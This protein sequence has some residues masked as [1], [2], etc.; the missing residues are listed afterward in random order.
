MSNLERLLSGL[1]FTHSFDVNGRASIADLLQSSERC[2][3]YVLHCESAEL[4][5]GLSVNVVTRYVQHIKNHK[6]IV[7][8]SFKCVSP[9]KLATEEKLVIW[10]LEKSGV[11]LRNIVHTSTTYAPSIF[12]EI[13]SA[14]E[15]ERWLQDAN[16]TDLTGE[17]LEIPEARRKY[18][19][20]YL[21]FKQLPC[22]DEVIEIAREY[23]RTCIP[24]P[25]RSE[26]YYWSCSCL[27]SNLKMVYVR[28]NVNRQ[29]VFVIQVVD[30]QIICEWQVAKTPLQK[31]Y[32]KWLVYPRL[33]IKHR[34]V[35][36]PKRYKPGGQD[37][38]RIDA[39]GKVNAFQM[40]HDPHTKNSMRLF[41]L[42]LMRKG[43]NINFRSHCF[44]LADELLRS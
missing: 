38:I 30:G 32:G 27:P 12:D 22:A 36:L 44:D 26:Y 11:H 9:E 21:R 41:N 24:A 8:L 15:Q 18:R 3:I 7:K 29:E 6:D 33:F 2:G 14:E 4:Y 31:G 37:Q 16:Y 35:A 5:A 42:R 43:I 28:I 25:L 23:V 34:S 19:S 40:L 13:M 39:V 20:K 17:R 1:G 10:E